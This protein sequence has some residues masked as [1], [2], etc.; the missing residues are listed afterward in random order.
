MCDEGIRCRDFR[1]ANTPHIPLCVR[2]LDKCSSNNYISILVHTYVVRDTPKSLQPDV[3]EQAAFFNA[4]ADPTRLKLIKQLQ[5]QGD[6]NALCVS[7]L[8]G[9]LQV[10]QSAVSQH[11]RVLKSIGLVRGE[12][13][14]YHMHYFINQD[15]LERYCGL[16]LTALRMETSD[17]E[18]SYRQYCVRRRS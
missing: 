2:A 5:R 6:E 15:A 11:L 3:E 10:S 12:R 16:T 13:R 7:A 8:A 9:F 17:E 18:R 14:G 4:L 1:K